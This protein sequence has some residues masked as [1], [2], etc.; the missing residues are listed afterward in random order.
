M[1]GC[2]ET[3]FEASDS[4][5][6]RL[7]PPTCQAKVT[8]WPPS[9]HD[10]YKSNGYTMEGGSEVSRKKKK[11]HANL[12]SMGSNERLSHNDLRRQF[13]CGMTQSRFLKSALIQRVCQPA[14]QSWWRIVARRVH[15]NRKLGR[16]CWN[17]RQPFNLKRNCGGCFLR[18]RR[19]ERQR[20]WWIGIARRSRA[21][22]WPAAGS[23]WRCIR[24]QNTT[25]PDRFR[26]FRR[27]PCRSRWRTSF[28]PCRRGLCLGRDT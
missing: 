1:F 13:R 4:I 20:R 24:R 26:W 23:L 17:R 10:H 21:C 3:P 5:H 19:P 18:H 25:R 27:R 9:P 16:C 12:N 8:F 15:A 22:R 2:P 6:G 14:R 7:I 11:A 28:R